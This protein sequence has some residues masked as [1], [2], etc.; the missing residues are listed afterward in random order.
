MKKSGTRLALHAA[1]FLIVLSA[2]APLRAQSNSSP[3]ILYVCNK[4]TVPVVVL[5][6][7]KYTDFE[8]GLGKH[9]WEIDSNVVA[10]AKCR[11]VYFNM[12]NDPV[13][14]AFAFEDAKGLW[15]S[16]K[17][18]Q[19]PDFGTYT[20]W[21]KS[22]PIMS[23]GDGAINVC[24]PLV[25]TAYK[26]DDNPKVDCTTMHLTPINGG[27]QRVN[28]PFVPVT[29]VLHFDYE[30][31]PCFDGSGVTRIVRSC[32]FYLNI[33]PDGTDRELHAV[34]GTSGGDDAEPPM[35]DAQIAK[36]LA[37]SPFVKALAKAAAENRQK[38]EQ[39]AAA[40]AAERER[41]A[42]ANT[43]E[44]RLKHAQE[45]QA[46]R[47]AHNKQVLAADAAGNPN[48]KVEAQMIRREQEDNRQRW[49]G[50]PQSP[51]A[52]DPQ[53]MG[54]NVAIVG[55]VSRVE[56]D[57]DGSP[58]WLTIYFKESPNATFVVCSPYPDMFQE[59]VGL[60]LSVLIGKTI[61]AAGQVESPYCGGKVPKGSIRVVESTQW[62][63]H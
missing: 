61:E 4:G 11:N 48:V 55:T 49:A 3:L 35:T 23:R 51:A 38:Q 58:Q 14:L 47:E 7:M 36:A 46:A 22:R 57:P 16:G 29:S 56:V 2:A 17:I 53:W 62:K 44:G 41:Q 12:Q 13:D 45:L 27:T 20:L 18:A 28:G 19:V 5:T 21:L 52:F 24:A 37:D 54:K 31:D 34:Q 32:N 59:R 60:N 6:V 25:N 40:A 30:G 26:V 43:P 9:S 39:A 33:S 10:S 63:I 8:R 15:G 42:Q 1:V 50:G